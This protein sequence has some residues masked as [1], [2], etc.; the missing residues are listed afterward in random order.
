MT[1]EINV[2][3]DTAKAALEA[4]EQAY[5]YFDAETEVT[6]ETPEYCEYLTAA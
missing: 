1:N 5:A 4:L 2:A 6:C 3:D